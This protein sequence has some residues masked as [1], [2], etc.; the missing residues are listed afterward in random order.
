[1]AVD[2]SHI[3]FIAVSNSFVD[4]TRNALLG[5]LISLDR[6]W[7]FYQPLEILCRTEGIVVKSVV[8]AGYYL[9][10]RSIY[11]YRALYICTYIVSL[12]ECSC[13]ILK[14]AYMHAVAR[15]NTLK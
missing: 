13:A 5:F 3:P 14:Y 4:L 12:H 8:G 6:R 7:G 1:M 9:R 11:Y 2:S 10:C 15:L